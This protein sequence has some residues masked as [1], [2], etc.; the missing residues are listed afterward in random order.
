RAALARRYLEKLGGVD[1]LRLPAAGHAGHAWHLLAPLVDFDALG[2]TRERFIQAMHERGIGVGVHY[3]A[4]HLF[5]AFPR[6]GYGAGDLPNAETIG[7]RTVTLP[8][9]TQL[10]DEDVERVCDALVDSMRRA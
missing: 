2:I 9:H 6:L 4:L 10:R 8:L 3:Q 7:A 5:E 1:R